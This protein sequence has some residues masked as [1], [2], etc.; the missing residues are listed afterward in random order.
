MYHELHD[1]WQSCQ[2]SHLVANQE[3]PGEG[4]YEFSLRSMFV[5]T[6]L[7]LL[8]AVNLTLWDLW[9]YFPFVGRRAA[10]FYPLKNLSP[11]P[12]GQA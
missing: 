8:H 7:L 11:R 4:N 9:L 10:Y 3:E 12:L 1:L 6:S 5:H 2:Q